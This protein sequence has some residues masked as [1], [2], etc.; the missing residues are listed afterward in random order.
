MHELELQCEVLAS[1]RWTVPKIVAMRAVGIVWTLVPLRLLVG[2]FLLG[3]MLWLVVRFRKRELSWRHALI[4]TSLATVAISPIADLVFKSWIVY[5]NRIASMES[6]DYFAAL[7][8]PSGYSLTRIGGFFCIV[9]LSMILCSIGA[10]RRNPHAGKDGLMR[11]AGAV[12]LGVGCLG[13]LWP[14]L[15]AVVNRLVAESPPFVFAF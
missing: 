8:G 3:T 2:S 9:G 10:D 12:G 5:T 13:L 1:N 11:W 4:C 14:W 7:I 15:G 6:H